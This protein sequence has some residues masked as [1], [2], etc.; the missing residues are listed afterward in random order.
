MFRQKRDVILIFSKPIRQLSDVL[1]TA[2]VTGETFLM[3]MMMVVVDV[4]FF[5][6]KVARSR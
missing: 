3:V 2:V 1:Q 5:N 4:L 6:V